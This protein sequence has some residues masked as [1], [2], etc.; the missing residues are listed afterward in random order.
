M[1]LVLFDSINLKDLIEMTG[2]ASCPTVYMRRQPVHLYPF[3]CSGL[4]C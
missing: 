4:L 2:I 3:A 1:E